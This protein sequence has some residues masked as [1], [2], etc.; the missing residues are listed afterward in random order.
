MI[1]TLVELLVAGGDTVPV[2]VVGTGV[3]VY[4]IAEGIFIFD[5]GDTG[6]VLTPV[7]GIDVTAFVDLESLNPDG[8]RGAFLCI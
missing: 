8:F 4:F 6:D 1:T 3:T 7:T 5:T 2:F